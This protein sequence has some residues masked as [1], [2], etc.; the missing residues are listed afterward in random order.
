MIITDAVWELRN[1][2]VATTEIQ[3]DE[4]DSI[5]KVRETLRHV[6]ADYCVV[7]VSVSRMDLYALLTEEGY[8]FAE[9]SIGIMQ[10][11]KEISYT[12]NAMKRLCQKMSFRRIN[13]LDFINE[14]IK[15]GMF[16]TDRVAIDPHFTREQ[17]ANRY[18]GWMGDEL[19]RGSAFF[20]YLYK[21]EPI[22]FVC[23]RKKGDN[24]YYSV[25]G[26]L[27]PS[28][29]LLPFG[30]ALLFK[31]LEIA[32]SMGGTVLSTSIS[33]NNVPA[34]RAYSMCG[35]DFVSLNYVFIKHIM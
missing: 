14:N 30:A 33:S 35:Y 10:N 16:T 21:D 32:K 19:R 9:V 29:N 22:G 25:L 26:G 27:Y 4:S 8:C 20:E 2:G 15:K 23:M 28:D 11:L 13:S 3:I 6:D 31:Q 34:F 17:A 12:S 5:S 1:M 18:V 24:E 7:K